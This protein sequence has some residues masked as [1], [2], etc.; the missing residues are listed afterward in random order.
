MAGWYSLW[1]FGIFSRFGMFGSKKI[2]A[3]LVSLRYSILGQF[4]KVQVL[5]KRFELD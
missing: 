5:L 1:P 4:S 2:L 3:T